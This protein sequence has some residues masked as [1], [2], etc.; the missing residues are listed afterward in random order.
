MATLTL[1]S[2]LSLP[3]SPSYSHSRQRSTL[4]VSGMLYQ[5]SIRSWC[6]AV[7]LAV[8][9]SSVGCAHTFKIGHDA[10]DIHSQHFMFA[11]DWHDSNDHQRTSS[12]ESTPVI[13]TKSGPVQVRHMA[14]TYHC[15]AARH[16]Y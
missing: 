9:A 4:Q 6:I 16:Q 3:L 14:S 8:V 11:S 1:A 13:Q 2:T 12:D 5:L 7:I 10:T 15:Q